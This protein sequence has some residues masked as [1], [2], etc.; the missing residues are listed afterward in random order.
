[1]S[2]A[3][4]IFPNDLLGPKAVQPPRPAVRSALA[5]TQRIHIA[6]RNP[7]GASRRFTDGN[8]LTFNTDLIVIVLKARSYRQ[9]NGET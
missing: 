3:L 7:T 2:L 9:V 5:L 6:P 1:M 4:P 8:V